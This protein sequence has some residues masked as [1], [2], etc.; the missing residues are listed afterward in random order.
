VPESGANNNSKEEEGSGKTD[1]LPPT[2][3]SAAVAQEKAPEEPTDQIEY[4]LSIIWDNLQAAQ[5]CVRKRLE[6]VEKGSESWLACARFLSLVL[7]RITEL[8]NWYYKI[9]ILASFKY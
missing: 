8:E 6:T 5:Q 3:D 1:T 2:N 7:L 9:N 4:D